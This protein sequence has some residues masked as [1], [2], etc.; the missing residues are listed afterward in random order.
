MAL[1]GLCKKTPP[2]LI[3]FSALDLMTDNKCQRTGHLYL[4][5]SEK[6]ASFD[7]NNFHKSYTVHPPIC[8]Y[9]MAKKFVH[10]SGM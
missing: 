6:C 8:G 1:L 2:P 4:K 3:H 5:T 10:K 9:F 7:P